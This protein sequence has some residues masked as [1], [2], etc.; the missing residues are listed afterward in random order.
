MLTHVFV[1]E[2]DSWALL[3]PRL[4]QVNKTLIRLVRSLVESTKSF[5]RWMDGTCVETPEQ[6]GHSEDDEPMLYTFYLD[7]AANPTVIKSTLQLTQSIQK[8]I[9]GITRYR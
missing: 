5:M 6:K 8:V 4:V 1:H 7:V 9:N 2:H 3:L